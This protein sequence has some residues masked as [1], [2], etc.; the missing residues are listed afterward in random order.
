MTTRTA[1]SV[2]RRSSRLA[3]FAK[4]SPRRAA[5]AARELAPPPIVTRPI[6]TR[7]SAASALPAA[8]ATGKLKLASARTGDHPAIHRL[9]VSVFHGPSHGEFHAQLDEPGYDPADRLVVRDGDQIAAHLRLA[10]QSIQAGVVSLPAA[11]FMDLATAPEYRN[12]GLATALLSAAE[13]Q[14]RERGMLVGI[15]RTRAPELFGRQGWAVCGR[16]QFSSAA[17]RQVLA[18]LGATSSGIIPEVPVQALSVARPRAEQ[19]AVRP[20]RRIELPALI[21]LYAADAA[22]RCGAPLRSDDYWDWLL[23][24]GACDRIYVAATLPEPAELPKLL[25]S[26]VG[27]VF[28][29]E[30]RIV[31][32]VTAAGR[33]DVARRLVARVCADASEQNEWLVRC[34]A[35]AGD[36]IH[37]L[38]YQA[39]GRQTCEQSL[40][41]EVFMARLFDPLA[42]LRQL[43]PNLWQHAKAAEL[44]RP[45]QLGLE[46]RGGGGAAGKDSSRGVIERFR[47]KFDAKQL[48]V[49]TGGPCQ[50]TLVLRYGDLAPLLLAD[51]PA[52]ELIAAQRLKGTTRTARELALALFPRAAWWR[53]P[54]DDLLA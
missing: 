44:R 31:E 46:L 25:E 29:R 16:H 5:A 7:P 20:L 10:R 22:G 6:V 45:L 33:E 18:E 14:A 53:P 8:A 34:D 38:F 51:L 37:T 43:S 13:R 42:A 21:R 28:V 47:L 15:T 12:R 39:G 3:T 24:R 54:L 35:A 19:I 40:A 26:I 50:H 23:A 27:Y 4:R 9:L 36:P 41:G 49:E 48:H 1:L 30:S 52:E 11:R 2:A 17:P 32:L